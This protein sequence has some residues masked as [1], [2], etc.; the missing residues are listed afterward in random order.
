MARASKRRSIA[1]KDDTYQRLKNFCDRHDRSVSGYIEEM[2]AE[3]LDD[4]GEP[5]PGRIEQP[6]RKSNGDLDA[7]I[8]RFFTF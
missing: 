3:R 5:E 7:L 2:V 4:A 8:K 1:V 6:P